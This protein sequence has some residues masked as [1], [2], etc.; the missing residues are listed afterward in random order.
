M[1]PQLIT[2]EQVGINT[3]V[4]KMMYSFGKANRF[5]S[6]SRKETDAFYNLPSTLDK[7][8]ASLGRGN[9]SDFTIE[10]RKKAQA[11]YNIPREFDLHRKNSPQYSFA[12][13]RNECKNFNFI[14]KDSNPGPNIYNPYKSFGKDA[15]K[16][17]MLGRDW[18][19]KNEASS[20]A[21]GPGQYAFPAINNK[22]KYPV[23]SLNNTQQNSFQK[24]PRFNYQYSRTP[25]PT[26]YNLNT[27]FNKTGKH[28]VSKYES[29]VAK[30]MAS[31]IDF[32]SNYV[33][34]TCP[35]PG[36]YDFF[37]DFEGFKRR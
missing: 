32:G 18:P 10:S 19:N 26:E 6:W 8:A 37:S 12:L 21:P 34:N 17:S 4:S 27:L 7:R 15:A 2:K 23:T 11:I 5:G 22:G 9:K 13:G 24:A 29:S 1:D 35:G 20:R 16:Y 36:Q 31:K 30:T 28:Y 3:S 33:Q 25:G 14:K